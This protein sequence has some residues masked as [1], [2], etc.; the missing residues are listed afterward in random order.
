MK[1]RGNFSQTGIAGNSTETIYQKQPEGIR[2][3]NE[4]L[5]CECFPKIF[6]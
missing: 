3:R 5:D 1:N 6:F 2:R 4:A